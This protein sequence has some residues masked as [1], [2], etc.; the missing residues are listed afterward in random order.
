MAL[1]D[2]RGSCG[3]LGPSLGFQG[4]QVFQGV[5]KYRVKGSR[6]CL[7]LSCGVRES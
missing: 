2:R 1:M 3:I 6:C 5:S 7:S 4:D